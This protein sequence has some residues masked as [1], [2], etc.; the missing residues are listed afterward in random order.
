[1]LAYIRNV[2]CNGDCD[3]CLPLKILVIPLIWAHTVCTHSHLNSHSVW[4]KTFNKRMPE[5]MATRRTIF[6]NECEDKMNKKETIKNNRAYDLLTPPFKWKY[7]ELCIHICGM[8]RSVTASS[9]WL[10]YETVNTNYKKP[11]NKIFRSI[12][13]IDI[14]LK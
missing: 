5:F 6:V 12:S 13:C 10:S 3:E 1:M 14:Y 4:E 2:K 8:A 11:K 7:Y 9:L